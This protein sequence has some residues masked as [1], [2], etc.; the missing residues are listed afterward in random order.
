MVNQLLAS[1]HY[2]ERWGR[3]WLD[4][5]K[6]ADTH[7]Y[8]KDK[9]R[10]NAWPYRDYVIR[11]FNDDK[12]YTQF[13]REQLAGDVV[14]P[15]DP[16]GVIAL[17]FLA[18]GPWDFI[19]HAE[20]PESKIDGM[21]A[22]NLDRDDMLCNALN[23]FSSLT[24]Q[25]AR[26]H[27]HKFDPFT[28]KHYYGLQAV[29]AAVDRAERSYDVSE[30]VTRK[31][32]A[33]Q[34]EI[35]QLKK[36]EG[37][38]KRDLEKAGGPRLKELNEQLAVIM[39]ERTG[40]QKP[41]EHGW[42]SQMANQADVEKWV[43][44]DLGK[45]MEIGRVI[46]RACYDDFGGIG[47]G[48]GFPLQFDVRCSDDPKFLE[49]VT[50]L[51]NAAFGN[52]SNPGL[53]PFVVKGQGAR[54]RYVRVRASR[55]FHRV[56][57]YMFSLAELEVYH[58]GKNVALG[59]P[60][61][62]LDSI[63]A[64]NRWRRSNLVD[65]IYPEERKAEDP[66]RALRLEKEHAALLGRIETADVR[67][68]RERLRNALAE[69]R[70]IL[71]KLPK[72]EKVY[73]ATVHKGSGNFRG[74]YGLGPREIRVL[75]RGEVTQPGEIVAPGALPLIPGTTDVFALSDDHDESERRAALAE[76]IVAKD[77]PTTW[78]SIVNRMW[79]YHFGRG[80]V[81]S[82]N[83]F[84][85]MGQPPSHPELLDWLAV[86]F[87]DGGQSFKAL[88][89]MIVT[90]AAYRQRSDHRTDF[91]AVDGDN[92]F[93]WRQNRR[94]MDAETLRDSILLL[95]GKLDRTMYGPG[96]YTFGLE[97]T[98]HSPHY[99]YHKHDPNDPTSH[100][101]SVYRF[102]VRSQPDPFMTTLDCADSSQSTPK[103]GETV[104]ALQALSLLNNKFNLAMAH[105]FS[106]RVQN[107]AEGVRAQV[108]QAFSLATGGAPDQVQLDELS[109]YA[110]R[111]GLENLC[112]LLFNLNEFIYVD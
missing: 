15:D 64:P 63:E 13:I 88:H 3:H 107:E 38:L 92:K 33:M 59:R 57:T 76:W 37:K 111:H 112:R 74:R 32:Y 65:G 16:D 56:D 30:K 100:R 44:V 2:G 103:R 75:H 86:E 23:T 1:P 18:A 39:E 43:Q 5:V 70:E 109:A 20:V 28:Q 40:L 46:L 17:G 98:T 55:L 21:V 87:R 97:Q 49:G 22:R 91:A 29:F 78:R 6:Y 25:C 7:G 85:R 42:H 94:R 79:Q 47:A 71:Q 81:D 106:D 19:G 4:V 12:P 24:I 62:A 53:A 51:E 93:L 110:E 104:T 35:E 60:V 102:I 66:E 48:F 108:G 45:S 27:D 72:G 41:P 67:A 26:C 34:D 8:D 80:L 61:Q 52:V 84:G 90:S 101:R 68:E 82:P 10:P 73:A 95:S 50:V 89:E 96:F 36:R 77:N 11:S 14:A 69:K 9:L 31:R 54:G 58:F 83:D 99:Q 105:H